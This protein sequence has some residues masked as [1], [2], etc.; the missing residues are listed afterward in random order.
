MY[1]KINF[2]VILLIF[3]LLIS[4][5][6][7][8]S[9]KDSDKKIVK[10]ESKSIT[11]MAGDSALID[12]TVIEKYPNIMI[13]RMGYEQ[14]SQKLVIFRGEQLSDTFR[15]IDEKTG[16]SVYTGKIQ[17]VGYH[18]LTG[19]YISHGTF[20]PLEGNGNYYIE[21]DFIGRSYSFPI[22][23]NINSTIYVDLLK[24]LEEALLL[25]SQLSLEESNI[26][27]DG[28]T[29][30]NLL[31]CYELY[32][33]STQ[34]SLTN[35]ISNYE[36][37][38]LLE[39][40]K[41]KTD[42]YMTL[43]YDELLKKEDNK[44]SSENKASSNKKASSDTK[45]S[46]DNLLIIAG[47][48]SKFSRLY[49]AHNSKYALDC[50]RLAEKIY[51]A[52]SADEVKNNSIRYYACIE[53]YQTTGYNKYHTVAKDFMNKPTTI[54]GDEDY[55]LYGTM[56]YLSGKRRVDI[57]LC[58]GLMEDL[59]EK[60]D[61]ILKNSQNNPYL[62]CSDTDGILLEEIQYLTIAN[63]V[64]RNQ[65]YEEVLNNH[66]HYFLGRNYY[67]SSFIK[68]SSKEEQIQEEIVGFGQ[69]DEKEVYS[70]LMIILSELL[71]SKFNKEK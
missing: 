50:I 7:G 15:V 44:T 12:Y 23:P 68:I 40:V 5:L 43:P 66:L 57:S 35:K 60:A 20:T 13:N 54:T 55:R 33:K 22:E 41:Q 26:E 49:N 19:E 65:E 31:L 28:K 47:N 64:N 63:Y 27:A 32:A 1:K 24:R 3:I 25:E 34:E 70:K 69:R 36:M 38:D 71:S 45:L 53:L 21:T 56:S 59:M 2:V 30:A 42:W 16:E 8:C 4:I 10:T 52:V 67:G 9:S 46:A 14:T 29:I 58:S 51:A 37:Q 6:C 61:T 18:S 11:G 39:L 17:S 48:L 62:V